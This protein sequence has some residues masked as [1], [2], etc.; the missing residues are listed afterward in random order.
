MSRRWLVGLNMTVVAALVCS[1]PLATA[2]AQGIAAKYVRDAGIANDPDVILTEMFEDSVE[3]IASRWTTTSNTAGMSLSTDRPAASGGTRSLLMTSRGGANTGGYLYKNLGAG[4]DQV[5][6]RYYVKYPSQG[7][8][9]H[10]GGWLGG[11]NPPTNW[12]QGAAGEKPTGTDRFSIGPEPTDAARRFDMYTYWMDM[13]VS[14]DGNYWGNTLVRDPSVVAKPDQWVCV[15][16]MVKMNSPATARNGELALWIDGKQV[17]HL[18][19]GAPLGTWVFDKFT[20]GPSGVPFEGFRWRA[21]DVLK[22][23][24]LWLKHYTT[25]DPSGFEG[26]MWWDNVVL[27]KKYIGPITPAPADGTPPSPPF[28]LQV[29]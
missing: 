15:E 20:P 28:Q 21:E 10:S 13:H 22:V 16:V 23:N 14:G 11:Y 1:L 18:R 25:A 9:H 29:R 6:L 24:W 4:H 26:R 12:P 3:A 2:S 19:Q 8:Y 27:A 7:T 5:F 17:I